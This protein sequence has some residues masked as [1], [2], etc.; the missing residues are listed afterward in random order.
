MA[1]ALNSFHSLGT[2]LERMHPI[3]K[4]VAVLALG[5]SALLWPDFTLGAAL[6]LV[7]VVVAFLSKLGHPFMKLILGFGVPVAVMLL[8]IQGGYSSRNV[9]IIADW[10]FVRFGLEGIEHAAK[11]VTTLLVFLGSFYL[12]NKTTYAGRL[13]AALTQVGVSSKIGYLILASLNVVP[14]MQ[15]RLA[16]IQQAQNAR[17][18]DT[19]GGLVARL[20]AYIPIL[21]PVVLSSLTDAQERGMTLETRGFGIDGVRRTSYVQVHARCADFVVGCGLLLFLIMVAVLSVMWHCGIIP[22]PV[23]IGGS[24]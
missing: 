14:Q 22:L 5:L 16:V 11:L 20:K 15:L 21:G 8:F 23:L 10:G 13:V 1:H 9:T 19:Q 17:G 4:I 2:P 12:M 6:V 24:R 3:T 7:L 18:L